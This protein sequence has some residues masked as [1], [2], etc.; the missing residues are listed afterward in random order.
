M[1]SMVWLARQACHI[2]LCKPHVISDINLLPNP[3]VKV[4]RLLHFFPH[5]MKS[6]H[7]RSWVNYACGSHV[8]KKTKQ[9]QTKSSRVTSLSR[10]DL[11]IRRND[12]SVHSELPGVDRA[13]GAGGRS[14]AKSCWGE[15]LDRASAAAG[16]TK[17]AKTKCNSQ[18]PMPGK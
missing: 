6:S 2:N 1:A 10:R 18:M 16:S 7:V 12:S 5:G 13:G 15:H 9:N 4:Q 3:A 17:M 8:T 14:E 11:D